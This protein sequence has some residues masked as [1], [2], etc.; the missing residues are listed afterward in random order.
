M[1]YSR[2]EYELQ[3]AAAAI[4]SGPQNSIQIEQLKVRNED[5]K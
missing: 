2:T 5:F 4:S 1:L 3:N